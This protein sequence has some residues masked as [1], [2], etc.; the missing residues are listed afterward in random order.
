LSSKKQVIFVMTDTQRTDML[1][2]YG[3]KDMKTPFFDQLAEQG[4]R[5]EKA[6]T[7]QPVCGPARSSIFTGLFPHS[8]GSWANA[9]PLSDNVKTVGQ[10]L[11]DQGIRTAYIGKWHLDAGDYFG[12]GECP[13]GWDAEYWYD[14]KNYLLE[15][16]G[17]ERTASRSVEIMEKEGVTEDFTFAHRVS[18]RAV[19]FIQRYKDD[20]FFLVVSYD[21][22]HHPYVCPEPY[23]SMYKDYELRKSPNVWD[24][25][26]D[27][28]EHQQVWSGNERFRNKDDLKIQ[29]QFFFGCN[30]Y[31]DY[32]FGRVLKQIEQQIPDAIVIY[33]SDHGDMLHN[34]SLLEKGPVMYEEVTRIP[35]I[36]RWPEMIEPGTVCNEI[37]SHVDVTPTVMDIF[38]LPIPKLLEGC[39]LSPIFHNSEETLHD[40]IFMEFGRFEIDHDGFGG[41]QPIRA[42]YDGRYKLILNLLTSD[43][44]YDLQEDPQE[45][46][47]LISKSEYSS[48]RKDLH[49][50]ILSWMNETRDPFRGYYWENRPWNE[51]SKPPTWSCTGM[52][53]QREHE[54]YEPR[55]FDYVTGQLMK[56]AVRKKQ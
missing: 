22:P 19:D 42:A 35:F 2:C 5:F 44:L 29:K 40:T 14:M 50:K 53:R 8:N 28:P 48:I 34:H 20:D 21:E 54:E 41:F 18:N 33:T 1:G 47:N 24:N 49:Q 17:D 27:K 45:M 30:S 15:L 23:S 46:K 39:S 56:E 26:E 13:D 25:L 4:M 9:M 12:K 16:D 37:V 3:N 38:G 55:Q 6:Y 36:V 7:T 32:E 43:E 51:D 11:D 52:T 31:V 10:R